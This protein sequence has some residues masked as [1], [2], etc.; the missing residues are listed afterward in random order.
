[1]SKRPSKAPAELKPAEN[2]GKVFLQVAFWLALGWSLYGLGTLYEA[3][4]LNQSYLGRDGYLLVE[5]ISQE[6]TA[7]DGS[8]FVQLVGVPTL[9]VVK[10][11]NFEPNSIA[12]LYY[13]PDLHSEY[14]LIPA[15]QGIPNIIS[16]VANWIWGMLPLA[17]LLWVI[18]RLN[19]RPA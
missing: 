8:A 4:Q 11:F 18:R 13:N 1:M 3:Y 12:E 2:S 5:G 19:Q 6:L 14:R 16:V 17:A 10:G 15:D 9:E 7:D